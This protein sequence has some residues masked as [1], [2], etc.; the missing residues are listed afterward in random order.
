[1]SIV[2]GGFTKQDEF[3]V[4][5]RRLQHR[6]GCSN[7][8]CADIIET[9]RKYLRMDVSVDFKST[10]KKMRAVAGTSF[11]RLNGCTNCHKHVFKPDDKAKL[12]PLCGHNSRYDSKGK[13]CEEVFYFPIKEKLRSLLKTPKYREMC[14]HEFWR[15]RLKQKENIMSDVYDSPS[16]KSFM[17]PPT[18][19]V[20]RIGKLLCH[21]VL[22]YS[23]SFYR[24]FYRPARMY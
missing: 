2:G 12:C 6:T 7:A 10:D 22:C 15:Q 17:G 24:L 21:C 9:F 3:C 11:L 18:H 14:G 5:I 4:S 23:N 8:T 19:P 20:K 13:P 16:W 1:M